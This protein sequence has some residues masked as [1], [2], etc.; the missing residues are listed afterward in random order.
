M[1]MSFAIS[2]VNQVPVVGHGDGVKYKVVSSDETLKCLVTVPSRTALLGNVPG[3]V[4]VTAK[5][6]PYI[7]AH[8]RFN[9]AAMT[10]RT[11]KRVLKV[12]V[13]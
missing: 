12:H 6:Y 7:V 8:E 9:S 11:V 5:T 3:G 10:E 2:P 13:G 1:L 4:P